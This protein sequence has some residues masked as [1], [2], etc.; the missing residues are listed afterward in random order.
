MAKPALEKQ[1]EYIE[2]VPVELKDLDLNS[3]R[4]VIELPPGPDQ[5]PEFA[6]YLSERAMKAEKET[7]A[8]P[9]KPIAGHSSAPVSSQNLFQKPK[10]QEQ[11]EIELAEK[12]KPE[13]M[14][15][16]NLFEDKPGSIDFLEGAASGEVTLANA[17][18]FRYA[19]F[20]NQ[21]K[22]SISFYWN[23][24]PAL[25]LVPDSTGDLITTIRF[26]LDQNGL[27][28]DLEVISSSGFQAI[29]RAALN[30]IKSATPVFSVPEDLLDQNQQLVIV[31][32]FRLIR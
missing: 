20:F 1:D 13:P 32:E 15:S 16:S 17:Y 10:S 31:C 28:Q 8:P 26:A 14:G 23:P 25:H 5:Q 24:L 2:V 30:A 27:L 21:L 3:A 19:Y 18:K 6:R 29:D 7:M 22:R 4:Q 9:G 12:L 11:G